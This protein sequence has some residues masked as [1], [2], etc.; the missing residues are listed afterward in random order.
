MERKQEK[1][2]FGAQILP[3][4]ILSGFFV[5]FIFRGLGV[6]PIVFAD[7]TLHSITARLKEISHAFSP[8]FAFYAIYQVTNS[9]GDAFLDCARTLN[10][11]LFLGSALLFYW[12]CLRYVETRYA[13]ILLV[14][15]L[16]APS[17]ILLLL[18]MPDA[19]YYALFVPFLV[20][21][22]VLEGASGAL[23]GGALL[24]VMAIVKTNA[25]FVVVGLIFFFLI[26]AWFEHRSW[27]RFAFLSVVAVGAFFATRTILAVALA[28]KAGLS[29]TG[30]HYSNELA[31]ALD[32]WRLV[33]KL[34]LILYA[35]WGHTMT[36]VIVLGTVIACLFLSSRNAPM[37]PRE[38]RLAIAVATFL[39]PILGATIV[40]S[41]LALDAGQYESIQRLSVRYYSFL[42][43]F[44]Y[45]Y[46]LA[47]LSQLHR[48]SKLSLRDRLPPLV[49][50]ILSGA[51]LFLVSKFFKPVI[52]E[53]PE[54]WLLVSSHLAFIVVSFAWL[55]P[56]GVLA[57]R[58]AV[59]APAYAA[60]LI[61]IS[62]TWLL[63]SSHGVLAVRSV[64]PPFDAA[65]R[66]AALF[67]GEE[68]HQLAVVSNDDATLHQAA[69]HTNT[70][71]LELVQIVR[72]ID[73][74]AWARITSKR[75]ALLIGADAL[76]L[77]P[78]GTRAPSG[79]V[80]V[81]TAALLRP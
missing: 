3:A 24:G 45:L 60:S 37:N 22:V 43:P 81:P 78:A 55:V 38:R 73:E 32:L 76:R 62:A 2:A 25:M 10:I 6:Q 80:L 64:I 74:A 75:W 67:L 69:F 70:L 51:S 29:F 34:P 41:A 13:L 8:S 40:F 15:Y 39:A 52:I 31:Q 61:L 53:S 9:C 17:N 1:I 26:E 59:A 7:E 23:I 27:R 44:A 36:V 30:A 49:L 21:V 16:C 66:Y 48:D 65:G 77:A 28:G 4:L 63:A 58:P 47:R 19:M 72:G 18:F 79:F 35:G 57:W 46:A 42:F 5:Y 56:L 50:I 11:L 20:A 68:R 71:D 14:V 12:L 33:Q 54:V